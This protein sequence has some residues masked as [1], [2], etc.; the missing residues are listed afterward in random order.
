MSALVLGSL[1]STPC[2]LHDCIVS[3]AFFPRVAT[4]SPCCIA[5]TGGGDRE[6]PGMLAVAPLGCSPIVSDCGLVTG[7]EGLRGSACWEDCVVYL[8][9]LLSLSPFAVHSTKNCF[10][11]CCPASSVVF[12]WGLGGVRWAPE[13]RPPEVCERGGARSSLIGGVSP[14]LWRVRSWRLFRGEVVA[15]PLCPRCCPRA[16]P[17][18]FGFLLPFGEA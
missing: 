15:P 4:V 1:D 6:L 18:P 17:G 8:G 11:P 10:M 16:D 12:V 5:L 9:P 14:A 13:A 2:T 3:D 7:A